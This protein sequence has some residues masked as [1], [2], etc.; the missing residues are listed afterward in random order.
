M[1]TTTQESKM[2]KPANF[3]LEDQEPLLDATM[4]APTQESMIQESTIQVSV[5]HK[6]KMKTPTIEDLRIWVNF[7]DLQRLNLHVHKTDCQRDVHEYGDQNILR[8]IHWKISFDGDANHN[9][10]L[11]TRCFEGEGNVR[12][13]YRYID[14]NCCNVAF[15]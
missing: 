4:E 8:L 2:Q 14:N 7:E 1:E 15:S 9:N 10:T 5:I 3:M 11:W 12:N 6:S 13:P